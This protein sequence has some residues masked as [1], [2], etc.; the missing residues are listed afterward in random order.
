MAFTVDYQCTKCGKTKTNLEL[1]SMVCRC[2]GDF[3]PVGECFQRSPIFD[4]GYCPT[5]RQYV[6]SY[7]DQEKKAAAFRSPDHPKGF[8]ILNS[9]RKAINQAKSDYKNREEIKKEIYAK[10]GLKYKVGSKVHF[11]R[12]LN[13][14]VPQGTPLSSS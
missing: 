7:S 2:G 9:N 8:S 6:Y 4:E 14:F 1:N 10:K 13:K 11:D 5:L 12:V 3:R